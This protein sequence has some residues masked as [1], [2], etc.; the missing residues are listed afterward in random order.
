MLTLV[1]GPL[2]LYEFIDEESNRHFFIS[3]NGKAPIY[4]DFGRYKM[5]P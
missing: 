2:S 1:E 4:L 3:K 5:D